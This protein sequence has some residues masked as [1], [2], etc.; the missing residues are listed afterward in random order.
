MSFRSRSRCQIKL[1]YN[2]PLGYIGKLHHIT[3][4]FYAQWHP[5][6]FVRV[7]KRYAIHKIQIK[8][9]FQF[10]LTF[11]TKKMHSILQPESTLLLQTALIEDMI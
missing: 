4:S 3:S 7:R 5:Q 2:T 6:P 1:H 10:L 9:Y 11:S 8:N